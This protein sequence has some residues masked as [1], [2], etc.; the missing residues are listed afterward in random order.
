VNYD[1]ATEYHC[2]VRDAA[3]RWC[4][5]LIDEDAKICAECAR[6]VLTRRWNP[7]R[8]RPGRSSRRFADVSVGGE[9]IGHLSLDATSLGRV[10]A[11]SSVVDRHIFTDS[12]RDAVAFLAE[13]AR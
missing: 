12:V 6:P 9:K 13:V 2:P 8:S 11:A 10:Y 4:D 7:P 3:G 5:A 1:D